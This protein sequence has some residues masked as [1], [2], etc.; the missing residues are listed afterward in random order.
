MQPNALPAD[1]HAHTELRDKLASLSLPH[2]TGQALS[3]LAAQWSGKTYKL[4]PNDLQIESIAIEFGADHST[5]IARTASGERPVRI[6]YNTW[7]TG[8]TDL[9][10]NRDQPVAS[11]GAWTEDD[12]FE[13]RVCFYEGEFCPVLRFRFL[14]DELHLTMDPNVSWGTPTVTMITGTLASSDA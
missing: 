14:R 12:T 2:P 6:G 10:A 11:C 1:S 5:Y 4:E 9:H 13:M 3:P 7:L 8:T